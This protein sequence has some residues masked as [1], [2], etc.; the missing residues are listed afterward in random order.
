MNEIRRRPSQVPCPPSVCLPSFPQ[1]LPAS[2]TV[3]VK[4]KRVVTKRHKGATWRGGDSGWSSLYLNVNLFLS[5]LLLQV[6]VALVKFLTLSLKV[7]EC[8]LHL[9]D[10]LHVLRGV[11]PIKITIQTRGGVQ[12]SHILPAT[13]GAATFS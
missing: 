11:T 4:E 6:S 10:Q 5:V 3:P 9:V 12:M 8:C 7:Q 1:V 13:T 2:S